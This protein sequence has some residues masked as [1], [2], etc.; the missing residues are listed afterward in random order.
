[1]PGI[2]KY[3][4]LKSG[5]NH[6]WSDG[7]RVDVTW[8]YEPLDPADGSYRA[9]HVRILVHPNPEVILRSVEIHLLERLPATGS[10]WSD[11]RRTLAWNGASYETVFDWYSALRIPEQE[12][13]VALRSNSLDE[14]D[15]RLKDPI[16]RR[17]NFLI[18]LAG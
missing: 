16:S 13:H 4:W 9:N 5:A 2:D 3:V 15:V 7:T 18:S 11:I 14:P 10:V 12:L 6:H 1:M 17:F 8:N